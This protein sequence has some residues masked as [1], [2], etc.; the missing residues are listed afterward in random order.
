M[1]TERGK[2]DSGQ[3]GTVASLASEK[4]A[5]WGQASVAVALDGRSY[6]VDW[7]GKAPGNYAACRGHLIQH[8]H[9]HNGGE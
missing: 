9:G 1:K 6:P 7:K 4:V 3:F 2:A 8:H 5:D